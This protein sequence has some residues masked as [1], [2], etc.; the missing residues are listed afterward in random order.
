MCWFFFALVWIGCAFHLCVGTLIIFHFAH[1][2][3]MEL[4]IPSENSYIP[5]HCHKNGL[6]Y[7]MKIDYCGFLID[8]PCSSLF[9]VHTMSFFSLYGSSFL[10]FPP[11]FMKF[12]MIWY[13]SCYNQDCFLFL[14][15]LLFSHD[16][17]TVITQLF[18]HF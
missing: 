16:C 7:K 11:Y 5:I 8:Q 10:I 14:L 17:S 12:E 6:F 2:N 4:Q 1:F 15:I 13:C 18:S 9:N 3:M